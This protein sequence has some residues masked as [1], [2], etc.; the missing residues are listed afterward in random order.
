MFECPFC[1][2]EIE[3]TEMCCGEVNHAREIEEIEDEDHT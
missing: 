2:R 3:E 1:E